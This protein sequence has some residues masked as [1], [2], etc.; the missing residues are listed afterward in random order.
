VIVEG[1]WATIVMKPPPE[2]W[3]ICGAGKGSNGYETTSEFGLDGS[4]DGVVLGSW[5]WEWERHVLG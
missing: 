4:G 1:E 3:S 5:E 2:T